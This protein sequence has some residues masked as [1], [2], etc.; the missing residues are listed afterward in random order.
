MYLR[1][2]YLLLITGTMSISFPTSSVSVG[3]SFTSQGNQVAKAVSQT[4]QKTQSVWAK[5]RDLFRRKKDEAGTHGEFC[6]ISPNIAAYRTWSDQPLFAWEGSV[7]I[8][9]VRSS[10]Y[11]KALWSYQVNDNQ[12][13][14]I[15]N[16]DGKGQPLQRGKEYYYWVE[17]NTTDNNG[18][19][20]T[21]TETI[22]F[23]VMGGKAYRII[24]AELP[25]E[26]KT[27]ELASYFAD[28]DLF[29]DVVRVISVFGDLDNWK[30][31]TEE[32]YQKFCE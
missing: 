16:A 30:I 13:S 27:A 2:F 11:G 32:L 25:A 7:N 18:Q 24:Q 14:V 10:R 31:N 19:L 23:Q 22:P 21:D 8:I 15:Y 5:I 26:H 4:K 12:S 28:H 9:Q 6:S 29:L 3:S 1:V 17:Y 20:I